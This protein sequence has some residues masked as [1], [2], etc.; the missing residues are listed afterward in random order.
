MRASLTPP[1]NENA[2]LGVGELDSF[3][4]FDRESTGIEPFS[5]TGIDLATPTQKGLLSSPLAR[6]TEHAQGAYVPTSV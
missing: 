5:M 4:G 2:I 1:L 6:I 3:R